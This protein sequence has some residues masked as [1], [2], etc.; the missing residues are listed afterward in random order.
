MAT[1]KT[2]QAQ[3]RAQAAQRLDFLAGNARILRDP[4]LWGQYHE[5]V[6]VIEL[7]GFTVTLEGSSHRV[8]P[9]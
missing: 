6:R 5:A 3:R 8:T 4:A 7:L 9:C 1:A 2:T